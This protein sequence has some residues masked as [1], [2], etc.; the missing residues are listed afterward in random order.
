VHS[1]AADVR[2]IRQATPRPHGVWSTL[3]DLKS[4]LAAE[5][6]D[7]LLAD[8][9]P[10]VA[11]SLERVRHRSNERLWLAAGATGLAVL[12]SAVPTL[13]LLGAAG[14]LYLSRRMFVRASKDFA[15]RHYLSANLLGL[16]M[17]LGMLVSG[18]FVLAAVAGTMGS[19]LA[20]VVDRVEGNAQ[21]QLISTFAER[22]DSVWVLRDGAELQIDLKAVQVGDL[23]VVNA[24]EVV[25]VDGVIE[26][27][28]VAIDERSLTGES[29]AVEKAAGDKVFAS[30]VLLF[31]R[32]T[33]RVSTTGKATAA[34]KIGHILSYTQ[35]YKDTLI[36][37]GRRISDR[38]IPFTVGLSA[39]TLPVLGPDAAVAVLWS[40]TGGTMGLLG[41]VSALVYSQLLARR[42]ILIKDGRVLESL[43]H[44]DT[45]VFDKTGTLTCE[46]PVVAAIHTPGEFDA[47]QVLRWAAAAEHR[48]EHPVAKAILAEA[49]AQNVV[50][51]AIDEANY[52]VGYGI[53]VR[54]DGRIV[55][56][57]SLRFMDR[58]G[59]RFSDDIQAVQRDAESNG[60]SLVYVSV[61]GLPA[62]VLE[63]RPAL[64]PEA[65]E[66]VRYL[67]RRGL[68]PVIISGDHEEPTRL[69][70]RT[71][72]IDRYFAD[73]APER[74]AALVTELRN[75]GR[76]VCFVGD[77]LNDAI[78]LQSAQV[79]VSLKGAATA[80]TDTAQ[81]I[82]MDGTLNHTEQLFGF[83]DEFEET[84]ETNLAASVVP[85]V[86]SL[87]GIYLLNFGIASAMGLAYLG[88]LFGLGVS[89]LPLVAHRN[90]TNERDV[91]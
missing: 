83:M 89:V 65:P 37:R 17:T 77:G 67:A 64:R 48:Q 40:N 49:A 74:K 20:K 2:T 10:S 19:L 60:H 27:G 86:M 76:F 3:K 22:S 56:V 26:S 69:V 78:A 44:V 79:S 51:P 70:A 16:A 59:L 42:G 43:R 45:V 6:R 33:V 85:G 8:L 36:T 23:L 9:D 46:Q 82:F 61:D 57:G 63:M 72:G 41:P 87:S 30:T 50:V 38:F 13:A 55:L 52:H 58:E 88:C 4:A 80:A 62:G 84:M 25:P 1:R 29:R 91:V 24:G 90:E 53:K 28:L 32:M 34:A 15:R 18:H 35:S 54:V 11:A 7:Q 68:T 21:R 14:V 75:E 5:G 39:V 12:G 73:V 31:G 81:I 71:L 66:V 47:R